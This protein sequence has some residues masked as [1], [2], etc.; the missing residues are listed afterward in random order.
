[1]DT[2]LR[3]SSPGGFTALPA[4]T[5]LDR[6]EI[7][8]VIAAGGFGI[9]YLC[10]HVGLRKLYAMKEHFPR[11]LAYR[12]GG[13]SEVRPTDPETFSWA[14][15][16]FLS[17]GKALAECSHPAVVEVADVFT[18]NG[19]AYMVLGYEQGRS[20]KHWLEELGRPPTQEEIDDVLDPL[21]G[22]LEYIHAR[23]LLHRDIAPDN[24]IIRDTGGACLIDF[25]SARQAVAERSQ[26]MSAIV[27][28]GYS[29]L[30]QYT[31]SG[32]SQG[33]WS[34]IYALGATVYRAVA[35]KPPPEATDRQ[36]DDNLMPVGTLVAGPG[37]YRSQFLEAIDWALRLK[38]TD[39][40]R[41]VEEWRRK[42]QPPRAASAEVGRGATAS[43]TGHAATLTGS[44]RK[45]AS[46]HLRTLAYSATA[47]AGVAALLVM[48]ALAFKGSPV[49]RGVPEEVRSGAGSDALSGA[50]T[51]TAQPQSGAPPTPVIE[52][53]APPRSEPSIRE[54]EAR[55]QIEEARRLAAEAEAQ[56]QLAEARRLQAEAEARRRIEEER[57]AAAEA[58]AKLRAEE[59]RRAAAELE[60]R[61][62]ADAARNRAAEERQRRIRDEERRAAESAAAEREARAQRAEARRQAER[63]QR[64]PTEP[65]RPSG[66]SGSSARYQGAPT[67]DFVRKLCQLNPGQTTIACP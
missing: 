26:F 39:R 36:L 10:R 32:R 64:A 1:M 25:G 34:D 41:T 51:E 2:M 8:S 7:I 67:S 15:D 35:G 63:A 28:S 50:A 27:K 61:A 29:P 9:T 14:L 13:T 53:A 20:M 60:S 18:A 58:E 66:S 47:L 11:Q 56:R 40:P 43:L 5:V 22:A 6:Y 23:G 33:P 55:R 37:R 3:R 54:V 16:R 12:D 24:I 21:L 45:G 59:A 30:E 42:V 48:A 49:L 65:A 4:G 57:A 19:T 62:A 17:E 44:P 31:R 46:A 38:P 52:P